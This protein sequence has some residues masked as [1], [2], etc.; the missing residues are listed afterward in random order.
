MQATTQKETFEVGNCAHMVEPTTGEPLRGAPYGTGPF[1][2][3]GVRPAVDESFLSMHPQMVDFLHHGEYRP[4]V[5]RTSGFMFRK[6]PN[7]K[8][9]IFKPDDLV[10]FRRRMPEERGELFKVLL[11]L[12]GP[13]WLRVEDV[14]YDKTSSD[15][16]ISAHPQWVTLNRRDSHGK[17]QR[18]N[19][20]IIKV[21]GFY[22]S[23]LPIE[24][25]SDIQPL[26][27]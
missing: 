12:H 24:S 5:A 19:S 4:G 13:D 18:S 7:K 25:V 20:G 21:S 14:E 6:V 15:Q 3:V 26:D 2:I 10:R 27:Q 8:V 11:D 9:D 17:W 22:L 1:W 16:G 23:K